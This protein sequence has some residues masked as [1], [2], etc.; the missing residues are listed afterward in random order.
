MREVFEESWRL[1]NLFTLHRWEIMKEFFFYKKGR[2]A[3]SE[4]D[5]EAIKK[6]FGAQV[7]VTSSSII[8]GA[9]VRNTAKLEEIIGV[10]EKLSR[11]KR[12]SLKLLARAILKSVCE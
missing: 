10:L 1:L 7:L 2:R 6:T 12:D 8:A 4:K 5:L 9:V 11:I 3:E